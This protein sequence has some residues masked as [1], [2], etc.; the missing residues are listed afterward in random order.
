MSA[1]ATAAQRRSAALVVDSLRAQGVEY[2]FG[3]PGAKVDPV[4]DALAAGGGDGPRLVLCRHEQNAAFMA[5]A[6]GRL[7]GRPGVVLV[8]SGPGTANLA[9][10]LVTATTEGDPVVALAGAVPRA[11]RLKRAHQS[12]DAVGMLKPCTKFAGEVSA[13]ENLPEAITH[14]FR[15]ATAAPQ[16]AAA[17]VTPLDVLTAQTPA[18]VLAALPAPKR[19]AAA[20]QQQPI[21]QAAAALADARFPVILVGARGSAP[22]PVRA[23][24]RLVAGTDLPVVETYQAAGVISRELE[25]HYF[26]RVGLWRNQPGDVLLAEADV[27]LTIGYDPV[28][29]DAGI[30]NKRN[31]SKIIHLDD[32][33]SE[34]DHHYQPAIEL[35]GDIAATVDAV[36]AALSVQRAGEET[37][38]VLDR[39]RERLEL[40]SVPPSDA[41]DNRMHPLRVIRELQGLI[42]D[43]TA[44]ACDVGSHYIWMARNFR[45]YEP[46][47][48]LFSN[49]QQTLGVALPWGIVA[50][51]LNPGKKAVSISGEGGFLFSAMELETAVRLG[52]DLVHIVWRDDSFDMVGFQQEAKYGRRTATDFFPVDHVKHAESYGATG[53]RVNRPEEFTPVMKEALDTPGVVVVEVPIDYRHNIGLQQDNVI[54]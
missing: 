19:L 36:K 24:R 10:G 38:A 6:V 35:F 45:S 29:Y 34:V 12:M 54:A 47:K 48:L 7:T 27:V 52:V 51:L 23:I 43:D 9:T 37:K 17:I 4:Y 14:A 44:V 41:D 15:V 20:P 39:E 8:T 53:I 1:Q 42:D 28:E 31:T 21:E 26:G 2:V 3:I 25:S 16:G 11:D 32:V 49:G 40:Q 46:R 50:S 18:H 13:P 5:G 30:W 22:E 33:L